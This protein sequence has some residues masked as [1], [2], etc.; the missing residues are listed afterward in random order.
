V[1]TEADL[2]ALRERAAQGAAAPV[3]LNGA[4]ACVEF[5]DFPAADAARAEKALAALAPGV[6][7]EVRPVETGWYMVY[8][9]PHKTL[10]EAERRAEELRKLGIKDLLVMSENAPLKFAIS[11]GSFRDPAAAK[12]HLA[13]LER[14]GVKGV[15]V[16]DRASGVVLTRF[17]LRDLDAAAARQLA[18]LRNEFPGQTLRP[19]T[20]G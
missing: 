17:Q 13:A 10:A 16:S 18:T 19:C 20:A 5:G 2:K 4:Q 8:L 7:I 6:T 15:R 3:D 1:L 12:S 14:L 11:L 9:P